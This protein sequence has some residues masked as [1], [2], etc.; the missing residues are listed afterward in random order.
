MKAQLVDSKC[1]EMRDN[2]VFTNIEEVMKTSF[3]GKLFED[4][5]TVLSDF[6]C[7]K[8]NLNS[9]KFERVHRMPSNRDPQRNTP[10]PI[11][12]KFTYFKEREEVRRSGYMLKGTKCGRNEQFPKE[13]ER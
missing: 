12:A 7:S 13:I 11:V 2:L 1:R 3:T 5:E 6:L 10:R 8:L 4:T 9:I